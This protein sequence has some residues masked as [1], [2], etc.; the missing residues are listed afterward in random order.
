MTKDAVKNMRPSSKETKTLKRISNQKGSMC[1][2]FSERFQT[3]PS[4]NNMELGNVQ[5]IKKD[6]KKVFK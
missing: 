4:T 6:C 5:P 1:Q 3:L 2:N